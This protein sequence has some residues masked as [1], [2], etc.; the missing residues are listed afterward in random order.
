M[1]YD[2]DYVKTGDC[3]HLAILESLPAWMAKTQQ[4]IESLKE[5]VGALYDI[6]IHSSVE[7]K[8]NNAR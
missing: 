8:V 3:H 6:L 2:D 4:D 7:E 5:Q 1:D